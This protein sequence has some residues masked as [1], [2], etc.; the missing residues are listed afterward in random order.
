M[1]RWSKLYI[2]LI[3]LGL[4]SGAWQILGPYADGLPLWQVGAITA[5]A[6]LLFMPMSPVIWL[7]TSLGAVI[8][9]HGA[10]RFFGLYGLA[11][12]WRFD[13]ALDAGEPLLHRSTRKRRPRR[14][15]GT[16]GVEPSRPD[17]ESSADEP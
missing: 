8:A 6:Q 17:G 16:E 2:A 5:L 14:S 9:L 11:E 3:W 13:R 1:N 10:L 12:K 4:N 15:Q 7:V